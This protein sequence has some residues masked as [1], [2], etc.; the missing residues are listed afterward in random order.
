MSTGY[1]ACV[2]CLVAF[3]LH[4]KMVYNKLVNCKVFENS[5]YLGLTVLYLGY[6]ILGVYLMRILENGMQ[7]F[8]GYPYS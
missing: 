1:L 8:K 7:L 4:I 3:S 2:I 5:N 6:G